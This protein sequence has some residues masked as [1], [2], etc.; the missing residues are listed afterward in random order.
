MF[1]NIKFY[2]M[3]KKTTLLFALLISIYSC[4]KK[5]PSTII[6][7]PT[8]EYDANSEQYSNEV[9]DTTMSNRNQVIENSETTTNEQTADGMYHTDKIDEIF[10]YDKVFIKPKGMKGKWINTTATVS[11]QGENRNTLILAF[12]TSN[13]INRRSPYLMHTYLGK[14]NGV[15]L[16]KYERIEGDNYDEYFTFGF[17][18]D[19]KLTVTNLTNKDIFIFDNNTN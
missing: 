17:A 10:H 2:K 9:S 4:G 19:G 15:E 18:D 7:E 1:H 8:Y 14:E 3:I 6:P 12:T 13:N 11:F 5:E 16:F